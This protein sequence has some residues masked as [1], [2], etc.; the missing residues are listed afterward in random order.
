MLPCKGHKPCCRINSLS[1]EK[2]SKTIIIKLKTFFLLILFKWAQKSFS[3][4]LYKAFYL[5]RHWSTQSNVNESVG[6]SFPG[7]QI[8]IFFQSLS[9]QLLTRDS[10]NRIWTWQHKHAN[11]N[12]PLSSVYFP[13]KIITYMI[14]LEENQ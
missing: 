7:F 10:R 9:K 3:K 14:T 13:T 8:N 5:I 12:A 1:S 2:Q 4:V 6:I 11:M